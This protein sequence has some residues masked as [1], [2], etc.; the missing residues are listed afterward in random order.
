MA[1]KAA[2]KRPDPLDKL[3]ADIALGRHDGRLTELFSTFVERLSQKGAGV[4]WRLTWED[5][6]VDE[7]NL[8]LIECEM[9]ERLAGKTWLTLDPKRSATDCMSILTAA[10]SCRRGIPVDQAREALSSLT[11]HQVANE[12]RS[13]YVADP[14]P[15]SETSAA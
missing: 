6:V 8:T 5:V 11:V 7:E 12:V 9:A 10:V 13:E 1:T 15:F 2:S 14:D 4:R 3:M